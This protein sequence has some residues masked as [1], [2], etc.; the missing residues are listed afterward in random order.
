MFR[1]QR[2]VDV[3]RSLIDRLPGARAQRGF[4]MLEILITLFLLTMWLLASAGVQ[5]SSLQFTKAA[6]FRTQ[7]VYLATELAERMQANKPAAVAGSYSSSGGSITSSTDCTTSL[8]SSGALA[9]FDL[10]EWSG[11]VTAA[12]PNATVSVTPVAIQNP[13]TYTIVVS[14]A[15]RRTD[16]TYAASGTSEAFSYTSTVIVFNDPTQ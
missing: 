12:L 11:R 9:T 3:T 7:A 8:C 15:D 6:A 4:S 10:A 2:G 16:R 14:W 5:S 13:I 1:W